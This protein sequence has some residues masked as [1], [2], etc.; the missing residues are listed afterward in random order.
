MKLECLDGGFAGVDVFFLISGYL[1]TS[2]ILKE[3]NKSSFCLLNFWWRRIRRIIPALLVMILTILIF[4]NFLLYSN[5]HKFLGTH[6][7][8]SIFSIA[9]IHMWLLANDYWGQQTENIHFL[10]TWSLSVEEQFYFIYPVIC[11]VLLKKS[12]SLLPFT[13]MVISFLGFILFSYFSPKYPNAT[14]YL[15]PSRFW[16]LSIGCSLALYQPSLSQFLNKWHKLSVFLTWAS[17]ALILCSFSLITVRNGISWQIFFPILGT[18][19]FI[20]CSDH[21]TSLPVRLLS[22]KLFT[23]IGKISYSLYLWHWPILL[24][25]NDFRT[26]SSF[27]LS[28]TLILILSILSYYLIEKPFRNNT[29][30]LP[31]LIILIATTCFVSVLFSIKEIDYDLSK[32]KQVHWVGPY[33][34]CSKSEYSLD[35]SLEKRMVGI[36]IKLRNENDAFKFIPGGIIKDYAKDSP[37]IIVWGDSHALMWSPVLDQIANEMNTSIAFFGRD[38][39]APFIYMT[40]ENKNDL[41]SNH[42][43]LNYIRSWKP[44]VVLSSRWSFFLDKKLL[45]QTVKTICEQ[46][47]KVV[48]IDQPPELFFGDHN[49]PISLSEMG[50]HPRT[51]QVQSIPIAK[52]H[53][54][55]N[56]TLILN[57]ISKIHPNCHTVNVSDLYLDGYNKVKVLDGREILYIDDDHLSLAGA[58]YAKTRL[59]DVIMKLVSDP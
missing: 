29:K 7:L 27:V 51:S 50:I 24:F 23:F 33:Y 36:K 12:P 48:L 41:I 54:L 40:E 45:N 5:E 55:H 42:R 53:D 3:Y 19:I 39:K 28:L 47:G 52:S 15:M 6:A 13:T 8:T 56:D 16:E 37:K 58:F 11:L 30:L 4:G 25:H 57:E 43:V 31:L 46:G 38:G 21:V 44:V 2:I 32:Y 9:N 22:S 49:A 1:I 34:D 10:H 18:S 17:L 14:F 20:A 35:R 26:D 59:S